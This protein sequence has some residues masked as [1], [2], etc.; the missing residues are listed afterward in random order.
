MAIVM[1]IWHLLLAQAL[2]Q[3]LPPYMYIFDA[4][5]QAAEWILLHCYKSLIHYTTWMTSLQL[6]HPTPHNV[7]TT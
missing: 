7:P 6:A 2:P 5:A 4:V 3:A 1:M